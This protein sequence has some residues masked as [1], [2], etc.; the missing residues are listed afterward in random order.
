MTGRTRSEARGIAVRGR[1]T[2]SAYADESIANE[3]ALMTD[4][5][6][7]ERV[8]DLVSDARVSMFTTMTEDGRHVSRPMDREVRL[9]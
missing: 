8:A 2:A 4:P 1:G 9:S 3:G 5:T 6:P 7:T